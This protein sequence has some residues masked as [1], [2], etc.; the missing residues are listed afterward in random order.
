MNIKPGL[1]FDRGVKDLVGLLFPVS[2]TYV[3]E[4]PVPDPSVLRGSSIVEANALILTTRNNKLPL[5]VGWDI[6]WSASANMFSLH[7]LWYS[8]CKIVSL[9]LVGWLGR[10]QQTGDAPEDRRDTPSRA[11][12]YFSV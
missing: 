6:C 7:G 4:N 2:L 11:A 5:P 1:Q 9:S 8:V 3:K 12:V 10:K